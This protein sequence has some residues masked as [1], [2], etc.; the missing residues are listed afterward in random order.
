MCKRNISSYNNHSRESATMKTAFLI[1]CL[2]NFSWA[3]CPWSR[4]P[5]SVSL[6]STCLCSAN[7]KSGGA[8]SVQCQ[9]TNFQLLMQALQTYAAGANTVIENLYVNNSRLVS[10]NSFA[11]SSTDSNSGGGSSRQKGKLTDFMSKNLKIINLQITHAGLTTVSENAFRGLENTL[12][13]NIM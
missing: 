11:D 2:I 13:V 8:L 9:A 12:Q 1:L 6:Q 7:P 3:Q 5:V 4:D 10:T